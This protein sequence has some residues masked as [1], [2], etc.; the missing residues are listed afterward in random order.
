MNKFAHEPQAR[1]MSAS[2]VWDDA[3]QIAN[4]LRQNLAQIEP[5]VHLQ[6]PLSILLSAIDDF[7]RDELLML[8]QRVEERLT[9]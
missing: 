5:T 6:I 1:V 4:V 9:A 3:Q 7:S 2:D 8:R